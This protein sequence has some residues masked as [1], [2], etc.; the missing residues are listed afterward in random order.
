[1]IA[2]VIA[3]GNAVVVVAAETDPCVAIAFAE[4]LATSDVPGGVVNILTG[5]GGRARSRTWPR[6][7]T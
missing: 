5:Y 6:T 7:P 1:M 2:P 4:V 3:S